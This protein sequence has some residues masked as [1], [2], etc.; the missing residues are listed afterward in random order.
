MYDYYILHFRA[1]RLI[2]E[3]A[4][5]ILYLDGIV[6]A[7]FYVCINF[8][9][10]PN[11]FFPILQSVC[12]IQ[13][14]K[15]SFSFRRRM[16]FCVRLWPNKYGHSIEN[17]LRDGYAAWTANTDWLQLLLHTSL[18]KTCFLMW[19]L[20]VIKFM[21]LENDLSVKKVASFSMRT[22]TTMLCAFWTTPFDAFYE[23]GKFNRW[24]L[25]GHFIKL[26]MS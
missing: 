19:S 4:S 13:R 15:R 6:G 25:F 12:C 24:N 23:C 14:R 5:Q 18:T 17:P 20:C 16:Y 2:V 26:K 7:Q 1:T 21:Y 11:A 8:D 9:F 22:C 3:V 10:F